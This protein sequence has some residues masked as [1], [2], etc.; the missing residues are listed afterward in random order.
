MNTSAT[1]PVV[2][3]T[4]ATDGVGRSTAFELAKRGFRVVVAARNLAKAEALKS[5]ILAVVGAGD[6]EF[7]EAD[8][9]SL[10]QVRQLSQTFRKRHGALDVLINNAGVFL[11]SRTVTEDGF[12]AM[13]QINYLSHFLLT[14]LLLDLLK[15][16]VQG[17]IINLSSNIFSIGKF[18]PHNLQ[19]ERHFSTFGAYA[20]SKLFMLMFTRELA[21]RLGGTKVTANAVHPGIVRTPMMLGAT[22]AFRVISLLSRP[23]SISPGKGAETSVFL[24]TSPELATVT[25]QYFT[26]SKQTKAKNKFDTEENRA[27]LWE[28]SEKSLQMGAAAVAHRVG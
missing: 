12:E 6:V 16:S 21:K 20:A 28:L 24:A 19:G 18:D 10:Q 2:L 1:K 17:R 8:L 7:I 13:Y 27:L 15:N 11:P 14:Q 26:R 5:E 22:G 9:T 3:I 4:G 25:G 23:F